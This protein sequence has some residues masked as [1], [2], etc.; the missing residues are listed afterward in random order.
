MTKINVDA[1]LS[2]NSCIATVAAIARDE[3][4]I[5]LGASAIVM[6]GVS[7]LETAEA[8]ACREGLALSSDLMLQKVR[9]AANCTNIVKNMHGPGMTPY[10]HIIREIKSCMASFAL[11]EVVYES[12]NSNGDAHRL[13][14]SS[15]YESVGA[16]CLAAFSF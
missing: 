2:N 6:E 13:A 5:F 10:G 4:G 7:D 1:T 14:K 8:L 12:R 15:I 3:V 16:A 9:I 11:V